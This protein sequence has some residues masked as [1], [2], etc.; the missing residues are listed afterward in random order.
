MYREYLILHK[1]YLLSVLTLFSAQA[2][3]DDGSF[4]ETG[5]GVE[6]GGL[7]S[8]FYMPLKLNSME[9]YV[10]T[11]MFYYSTET[12][13]EIGAGAGMDYYLDKHQSFGGYIGLVDVHKEIDWENP[14]PDPERKIGASI[15]YKYHFRGVKKSGFNLG[16]SYSYA[17]TDHYPFISLG[18]RF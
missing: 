14:W 10:A 8:K 12:G 5:L 18:Y 15:N 6:Y 9:V 2:L 3:S 17:E 4:I 13:G 11:G 1:F 16:I 7:G